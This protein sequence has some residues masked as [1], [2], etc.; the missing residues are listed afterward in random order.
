VTPRARRVVLLLALIAILAWVATYVFLQRR[1]A[2]GSAGAV[3]VFSALLAAGISSLLGSLRLAARTQAPAEDDHHPIADGRRDDPA[4]P[5]TPCEHAPTLAGVVRL[6]TKSELGSEEW[7]ALLTGASSEFFLAGHTLGKWCSPTHRETFVEHVARILAAAG[8]VK[9]VLLNPGSPELER[10]RR[11]T[12][13]DYSARLHQ[14]MRVLAEFAAT[15]PTQ[16]RERLTISTLKEHT[17]LPYMLVGNERTL[18]TATY[19]V[20]R[21]SDEMPCLELDR[22]SDAAIAIYDDFCELAESAPRARLESA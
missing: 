17:A 21:D 8:K 22:S 12:G 13:T 11:T 20:G 2:L 15:L 5:A 7:L 1:D 18:I 14:S 19:L 10:L 3:G 16:Q 6:A 9:L 4:A